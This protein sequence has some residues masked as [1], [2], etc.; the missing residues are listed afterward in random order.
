MNSDESKQVK[1]KVTKLGLVRKETEGILPPYL[2]DLAQR[3]I[4]HYPRSRRR[5]CGRLSLYTGDMELGSTSLVKYSI[6]TIKQPPSRVS[7]AKR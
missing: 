7:V 1:G 2:E 6:F 3:S 4:T 5:K